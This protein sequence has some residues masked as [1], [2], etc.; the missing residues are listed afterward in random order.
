[1]IS[2]L[3]ISEKLITITEQKEKEFEN[4]KIMEKFKQASKEYEL[5]VSRG[6]A[7]KRE[8]NLMSLEKRHLQN[9]FYTSNF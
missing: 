7:K 8:S 4:D 3:K 5:L 6:M 2:K 9:A 1:M